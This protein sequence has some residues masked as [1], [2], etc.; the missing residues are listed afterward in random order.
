MKSKL[1]EFCDYFC[2]HADF[3]E[4]ST[5]GACRKVSAVKCSLLKKMVPKNGPCL[6]KDKLSKLEKSGASKKKKKSARA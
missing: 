1:P 3:S 6:A 5:V 2:P 4:P